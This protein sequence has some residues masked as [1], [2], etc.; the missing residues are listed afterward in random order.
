[1][2]NCLIRTED[3]TKY[4][5]TLPALLGANVEVYKGEI[6]G[7]LGPNGSGKTTL[8]Q[9]LTCVIPPTRGDA[10]ICGYHIVR[11]SLNCRRM[12][13]YCSE[14][15]PLYLDMTVRKYLEFVSVLKE[16]K[17][18]RAIKVEKLLGECGL[19]SVSDRVIG[20]LSKGY[21]Q[22]VS[23]AQALVNDPAVLILD[24]PTVGL[25]PEQVKDTR[26][27][28]KQFSTERSVLIST[29]MLYEA[30]ILCDRVIIMDKG[31]ILAVDTP[32]RLESSLGGF[33]AI[34]L[35]IEGP[36]NEISDHLKVIPEVIGIRV[37]GVS[38]PGM[39][40]FI[41]KTTNPE[42][43]IRR[44]TRLAREKGWDVLQLFKEQRS[45]EDIFHEIISKEK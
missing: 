43:V 19:G 36:Q 15:S 10:W 23:L 12:I 25:D 6:V 22:R 37:K 33:H 14:K 26:R 21:R 24:E 31:K 44:V 13:G 45:L 16:V 28:I 30:G 29:H 20:K 3:L 32:E 2:N 9:I 38:S 11:D 4:Y 17:K 7:L 40:N 8:M 39:N 41:I 5:G 42:P 34:D 1:M 18:D 27:L 35:I